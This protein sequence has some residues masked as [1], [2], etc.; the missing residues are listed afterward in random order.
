MNTKNIKSI[1]L[2][3]ST[4]VITGCGSI[5]KYTSRHN[6]EGSYKDLAEVGI[7]FDA[8]SIENNLKSPKAHILFASAWKYDEDGKLN[9]TGRLGTVG[10][11]YP[12]GYIELM[13]GKY[14][15]RMHCQ[16]RGGSASFERDFI[17]TAGK[18]TTVS[19]DPVPE[20]DLKVYIKLHSITDTDKN[21]KRLPPT[22]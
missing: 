13:P 19:C 14:S 11:G 2:I 12:D 5:S 7:I 6:Y 9:R 3:I 21:F 22:N 8:N 17:I 10:F 1:L 18:T 15:V 4:L 20:N 16:A